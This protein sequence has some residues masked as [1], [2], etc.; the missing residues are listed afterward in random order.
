MESVTFKVTTNISGKG[1]SIGPLGIK[2]VRT[3]CVTDEMTLVDNP[4]DPLSSIMFYRDMEATL[5]RRERTPEEEK[6]IEN[7]AHTYRILTFIDFNIEMT[8]REILPGPDDHQS[9]Q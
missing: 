7:I 8:V 4:E 3:F 1:E 9:I 2:V 6:H 5:N